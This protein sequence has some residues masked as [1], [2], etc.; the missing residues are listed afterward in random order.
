MRER[1]ITLGIVIVVVIIL[2]VTYWVVTRP[3]GSGLTVASKQTV[4]FRIYAPEARSVFV[5]GSF[6]GWQTVEHRLE[7]KEGGLWETSV[8]IA[9]GRYEYKFVV[10]SSWMPD[11]TNPMKVPVPLPFT[12]YNSVL[13]VTESSN[14]LSGQR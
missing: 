12:G 8:P 14:S 3:A 13:E 9:P 11:P 4:V 1:L 2:L 10:D 6:N 7:R 5:S